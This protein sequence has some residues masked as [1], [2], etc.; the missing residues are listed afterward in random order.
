MLYIILYIM[1]SAVEV[2]GTHAQRWYMVHTHNDGI[3]YTRTTMVYGNNT[4]RVRP[5]VGT[6]III[7]Y[8]I[9]PYT[10][11][12][13]YLRQTAIFFFVLFVCVFVFSQGHLSQNPSR[14]RPRRAIGCRPRNGCQ[15]AW[16]PLV[17][18]AC[19]RRRRVHAKVRAHAHDRPVLKT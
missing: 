7:L 5:A 19:T 12:N 4:V 3:W 18:R 15:P 1:L 10:R 17:A 9:I 13:Y 8:Y 2:Y 6:H 14:K 11:D 16:G